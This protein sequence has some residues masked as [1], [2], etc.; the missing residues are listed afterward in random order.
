M[1]RAMS[2]LL[3]DVPAGS[4]RHPQGLGVA[5]RPAQA[6]QLGRG[7]SILA[8]AA[9]GDR[10]TRPRPRKSSTE[11][12]GPAV[13]KPSP[14]AAAT[15]APAAAALTAQ[16]HSSKL[17]LID[18]HGLAFRAYWGIWKAIT[19]KG[20]LETLS[21]SDGIPTTVTFGFMRSLQVL[22]EEEKP[23]ALIVAFDAPQR[24]FR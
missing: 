21:T 2:R 8:Q 19:K 4:T 11:V 18:G 24:S 5:A 13:Q 10:N 12:E 15:P 17:L 1:L 7:L 20:G 9:K 3:V 22:L 14:A 6:S 23:D 16:Q